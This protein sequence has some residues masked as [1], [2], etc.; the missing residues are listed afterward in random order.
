MVY[1]LRVLG[2]GLRGGGVGWVYCGFY[3]FDMCWLGFWGWCVPWLGVCGLLLV[4]WCVVSAFLFVGW[5]EF[6]VVVV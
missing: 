5:F 1:V 2:V 6:V 4:W 3:S